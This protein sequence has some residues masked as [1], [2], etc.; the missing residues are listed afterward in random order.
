MWVGG[1]GTRTLAKG[2]LHDDATGKAS[3]TFEDASLPEGAY[4]PALFEPGDG[5]VTYQASALPDAYASR[6]VITS[7]LYEAEHI[8]L[9]NR[10]DI[11]QDILGFIVKEIAAASLLPR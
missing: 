10:E 8:E 9:M 4:Q 7:R 5:T 11:R 3:I 2:F 6:F 1:T